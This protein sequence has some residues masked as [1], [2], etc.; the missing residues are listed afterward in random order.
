MVHKGKRD[1]MAAHHAEMEK[2]HQAMERKMEKK[3][4]TEQ[5]HH[6]MKPRHPE[7]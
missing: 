7:R 6:S 1:T 5:K 3:M 4:A 2:D